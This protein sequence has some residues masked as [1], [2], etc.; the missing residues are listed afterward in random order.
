[1]YRKKFQD[2]LESAA[3][4]ELPE[5]Y[6]AAIPAENRDEYEVSNGNVLIPTTASAAQT[7]QA[8]S[9][10]EEIFGNVELDEDGGLA[11]R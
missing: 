4:V 11:G 6:V 8:K 2:L 9:V 7:R 5:K 10:L 3:Y 1:M